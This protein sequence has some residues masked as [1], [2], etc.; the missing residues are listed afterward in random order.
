MDLYVNAISTF[1]NT[2]VNQSN[3]Q[4][5]IFFFFLKSKIIFLCRYLFL[6]IRVR[7]TDWSI[8]TLRWDGIRFTVQ[9]CYCG[10]FNTSAFLTVQHSTVHTFSARIF[11]CLV[12]I[13]IRAHKHTQKEVDEEECFSKLTGRRLIHPSQ[14]VTPIPSLPLFL[15]PASLFSIKCQ[16]WPFYN[17]ICN[18]GSGIQMQSM[19]I[20]ITRLLIERGEMVWAISPILILTL[21]LT[22]ILHLMPKLGSTHSRVCGACVLLAVTW[23]VWIVK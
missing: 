1:C 5:F 10:I 11:I 7:E 16:D 22:Y 4:L 12:H 20:R 19:S 18:L 3:P 17:H 8:T 14:P 9:L 6:E 21:Y 2:D 23:V 15:L 13:H